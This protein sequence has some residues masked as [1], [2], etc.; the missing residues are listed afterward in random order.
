LDPRRVWFKDFFASLLTSKHNQTHI[1]EQSWDL[2]IKRNYALWYSLKN[3]FEKILLVDDD[4]RGL[5]SKSLTSGSESLDKFIVSGCFV[6]DFPDTSVIGH[7]ERVTGEDV[8]PFLSGSFLF[9]RPSKALGFFPNIYNED[10]LFMACHILD[11]SICSFGSIAQLPYD[12]FVDDYR[13]KFQEFG[14]VIAEGL[15]GLIE[16]H[17][18]ERRYDPQTWTETISKRR[19]SLEALTQSVHN[20][21]YVRLIM[22]SLEI[23]RMI[24]AEDCV[25]YV[26]DWEK[27]IVM[28]RNLNGEHS[29]E[30]KPSTRNA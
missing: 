14:E 27:D 8:Y 11:G 13:P 17:S 2:P 29:D 22:I 24:I 23:N 12:P 21:N 20:P 3:G 15:Y 1:C 18:Y 7:L 9:L 19:T 4:I 25:S 5:T 10:W 26:K 6:E 28:W 16:D 30:C